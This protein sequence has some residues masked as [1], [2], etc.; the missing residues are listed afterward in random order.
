M[1]ADE[2]VGGLHVRFVYTLRQVPEELGVFGPGNRR[3]SLFRAFADRQSCSAVRET[4]VLN[5]DE[6]RFP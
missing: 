3:R 4:V 2:A 5:G 6:K 1:C